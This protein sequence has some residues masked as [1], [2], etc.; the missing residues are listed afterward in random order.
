MNRFDLER[1]L[2]A[3][4]PLSAAMQ[5]TVLEVAPDHVTLSAPLAPNINHRETL[6]GGSAS[7]VAVLAAWS[8]V[9][10]R[11]CD[12]GVGSRLV[13]QGNTMRFDHPV[14]GTFHAR[15]W[16]PHPDKWDRFCNMLLRK[17]KARIAANCD[18]TFGGRIAARFEGAFVALAAPVAAGADVGEIS[19]NGR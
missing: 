15:S 13:I 11:L 3:H 5:V 12:A 4:I 9:H 19:R 1:Y 10:T 16:L 8:L 18:L 7:A 6:F 2:H 17:G 14:T